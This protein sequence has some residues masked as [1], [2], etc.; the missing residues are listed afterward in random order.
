MRS[1]IIWFTLLIPLACAES[2]PAPARVIVTDSQSAPSEAAIKVYR[3]RGPDGVTHYADQ[4]PGT[5]GFEI[6][7]FE[8]CF[9]C[10]PDSA[11]DWRRTD[12]FV[13]DYASPISAA[14]RTYQVEPALIRAL[15]HA[16]SAF[17]PLVVS[18]KGA[19]GLTQLMPD[20]ARELGV[21]NAFTPEQNIFAGVRY[22]SGL[23]RQYQ[24]DIPLALAAYNAGPGAVEKYHGIPPYTETRAYVERVALLHQRYRDALAGNPR[25]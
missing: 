20:T 18:R 12:L 6:L 13:S 2:A 14:A 8:H 22:L 17:N 5:A 21:G 4:A 15:I 16:E 11:V 23:L 25:Q 10:D 9:A 24:G 7:W 19:M 1:P 3:Y